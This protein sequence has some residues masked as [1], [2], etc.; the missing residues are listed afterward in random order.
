MEENSNQNG[1]K[2]QFLKIEYANLKLLFPSTLPFWGKF[3][4]K[5]EMEGNSN[6]QKG[7]AQLTKPW[8]S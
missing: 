3:K 8:T 7:T 6:T 1:R 4:K 5:T 2:Q